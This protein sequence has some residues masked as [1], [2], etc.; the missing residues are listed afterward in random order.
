MAS[1]KYLFTGIASR[2]R[3][4]PESWKMSKRIRKKLEVENPGRSQGCLYI[5]FDYIRGWLAH[6][7]SMKQYEDYEVYKLKRCVRKNIVT[8]SK[9]LLLE[10]LLNSPEYTKYLED[11]SLFNQKFALLINRKWIDAKTMTPETFSSFVC[12][13]E[14]AIL[15]PTDG[16]RGEGIRIIGIPKDAKSIVRLYNSLKGKKYLVEQVI[17]QHPSIA[18]GRKSVNTIRMYTL[19]DKYGKA[20]LLKSV[21]RIGAPGSDVDNYHCGGS[22]WPLNAEHGFVETPGKTLAVTIPI[23]NLP[24]DNQFMLGF[25]VPNYQQAVE[26]VIKA[27]EQIPQVRYI[28]WDVAITHDGVSIIEANSSPDND[29]H[30]LGIH[31]NYFG[32]MMALVK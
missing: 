8:N 23:F 26:I 12:G 29:F 16:E 7:F 15:K 5:W 20:H 13:L 17:V 28:G 27:A 32:A 11:K 1:I 19:L 10:K 14:K 24:P 9:A 21:L 25:H 3:I 30:C 4:L 6:G 31:N 18:F 22:I 2:F